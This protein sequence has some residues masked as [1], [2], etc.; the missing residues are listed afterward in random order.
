M[1][2]AVATVQ[3]AKTFEASFYHSNSDAALRHSL[4]PVN[5]SVG[6]YVETV[7]IHLGRERPAT[8][9]TP[10]QATLAM[11]DSLLRFC[12]QSKVEG[13]CTIL[14]GSVGLNCTKWT[15]FVRSDANTSSGFGLGDVVAHRQRLTLERWS[16]GASQF[17][18]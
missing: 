17:L 7:L 14:G 5:Q 12:A 18:H 2:F 11:D 4:G 13:L 15:V 6:W 1:R 8:S 16:T 3:H 10:I 9:A